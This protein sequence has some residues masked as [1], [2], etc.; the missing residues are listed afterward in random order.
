VLLGSIPLP[1]QGRAVAAAVL[2]VTPLVY[3]S[4]AINPEAEWQYIAS[5]AGVFL[6]PTGLLLKSAVPSS[7]LARVLTTVG[8]LAVLAVWL[9][10]VHDKIPV[11][12]ALDV[13]DTKAKAGVKAGAVAP[14]LYP[15]LA[16][17]SLLVWLP[18][19]GAA[20]ALAWIWILGAIIVHFTIL[21]VAGNI[22]D[23]LEQSPNIALFSGLEML[24]KA[25]SVR[26]LGGAGEA[27][28]LIPSGVVASAYA[29][30]AGYGLASL[31]GKR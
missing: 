23:A 11:Q 28:L 1:A 21:I 26:D 2:G 6:I 4:L 30:F 13:L 3:A 20:K 12:A 25:M 22:G 14:L 31:L 16:I 27:M 29:A 19:S 10:P 7:M 8:A 24:A 18:A 15:L 17:V 5:A 9:V